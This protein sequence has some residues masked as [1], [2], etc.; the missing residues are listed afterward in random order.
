MERNLGN[1]LRVWIHVG[2]NRGWWWDPECTVIEPLI[3]LT[4]GEYLD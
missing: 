1:S 2:K 3:S 4:G